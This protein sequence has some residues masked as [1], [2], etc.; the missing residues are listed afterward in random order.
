MKFWKSISKNYRFNR[1]LA[2]KFHPAQ[3]D[4][5]RETIIRIAKEYYLQVSVIDVNI[6]EL[7]QTGTRIYI[8]CGSGL[9]AYCKLLNLANRVIVGYKHL[10]LINSSRTPRSDYWD[11]LFSN[12]IYKDTFIE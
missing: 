12:A 5:E 10:H 9:L 8:G 4:H 6:E 1:N 3:T 11:N 7:A 2:I